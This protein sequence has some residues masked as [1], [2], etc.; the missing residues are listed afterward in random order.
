MHHQVD[1]NHYSPKE[2]FRWSWYDN[3]LVVTVVVVVGGGGV[4]IYN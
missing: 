4:T 1:E 3:L 2:S